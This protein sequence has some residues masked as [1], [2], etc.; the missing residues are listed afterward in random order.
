[1]VKRPEKPRAAGSEEH[2][3]RKTSFKGIAVVPGIAIGT[4]RLK[5]RQTQV[6]S[7]R[8][9]GKADVQRELDRLSEA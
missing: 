6:W 7:D 5:F 2:R 9:I 8:T 4:V 1:M 3:R